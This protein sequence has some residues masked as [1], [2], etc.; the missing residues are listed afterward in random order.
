MSKQLVVSETFDFK[1]SSRKYLDN[2]FLRVS[3][4]AA[5]TG[6][7]EYLA[8]ELGITDCNPTDIIK[9]YR[10]EEEVFND[11]SIES[12]KNVDVTNDHPAQFV[13]S[14]TF[15]EKSVG[16]V[17]SAARDGDFVNVDV[18]I[19]DDSAIR[20][21]ESGKTQL[22]P[23]YSA[24][25]VKEDGTAPCG[26]QYQYKQTAIDINHVA[27]VSRGR[28]GS[29]VRLN[30]KQSTQP[31]K[32]MT[33]VVLDSGRSLELE[34]GATATLIQDSFERLAKRATDAEAEAEKITPLQ[35]TVDAQKEKIE[36]LEA[37][38]VAANDSDSIKT[39]LAELAQ[40]QDSARKIAG[41]DFVCDS[42][43]TMEIKRAALAQVRDSIDWPEK[44]DAYINAAFEFADM[45]MKKEEE[46]ED[47]EDEKSK[48]S[49]D[50][51]RKQLAK[52]AAAP[53]TKT[54]DHFGKKNFMDQNL[55]KVTAG[56][57]TKQ[58]LEAS[59]KEQFGG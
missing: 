5:R 42:V 30:D 23:G 32:A 2:G 54:V 14:K 26:T 47:E 17:I 27:I 53:K 28:G 25:Y 45:D 55:W 8:C 58:E 56:Q 9:V 39:K 34:D 6:V 48:K 43:D 20:D 36:K 37:D 7:Y 50:S 59:A 41:K 31:E 16:H 13:D 3:G 51:Q 15:R 29:Q 38:L 40:V 44:D 35:A 4:K 52:D 49:N 21:I 24:I 18:M 11:T 46:D 57:M 1:P 19:K 33:K 10:P 12:Y 22:S